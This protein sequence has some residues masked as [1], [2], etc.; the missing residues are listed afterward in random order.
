MK[1]R[2]LLIE[3]SGCGRFCNIP[4]SP[5]GVLVCGISWLACCQ[6]VIAAEV[7]AT[8]VTYGPPAQV[9]F[10]TELITDSAGNKQA[11]GSGRSCWGF[12]QSNIVRHGE[13][14]YAMCWRDDL[15]LIVFRRI[16]PGRWEASQPLPKVPQNGVLLVDS[17]GRIHVIAGERARY[18]AIFD[19]PGQVER[20][21]VQR[22][23]TADTRFGASIGT[24]GDI[25]VAGGLPAM[26][27]YLLSA[28]DGYTP[29]VSGRV[30]HQ[31]WRAYYFVALEGPAAHTF[32]YD[33]YFVTGIGYQTLKTYYS[34]NP[35]VRE[36]PNDW[37][38]T[39]VSDVSDMVDGKARG[40]TENEDLMIDQEG[41][42]H[43]LYLKNPTPST[44]RWASQGQDRAK[45]E[46]YH[47]VGKPG[48]PF[49]RYLLGSFSRGRLYQTPDG[50]IHY[51]LTRGEWF[52][53]DLWY[54]AGDKNQ[55]NVISQPIRLETPSTIDHVF[56]NST[57]AGGTS[58]A[59]IDCYFTG[60]FPGKNNN[61]WYGRLSLDR[62]E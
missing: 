11:G 22:L 1:I 47:A 3:L 12:N 32:C 25:L 51:L 28:A 42:V 26:S 36:K 39:V 18:H 6:A 14:V 5:Q 15:H 2:T 53:F 20:F 56:V 58:S 60:P 23:A 48:G 55:W 37:R 40:A 7:P 34:Y 33:D 31:S 41:R 46:L 29:A 21:K 62:S 10:E 50:R 17:R 30:P 44:T 57:R 49:E 9:R 61:V 13:H 52:N 59:F 38:T 24:R 8:K 4:L 45:D 27:W 35:N 54:A 19:P 16:G 43:L